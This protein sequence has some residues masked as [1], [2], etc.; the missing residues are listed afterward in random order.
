M[1]DISADLK[2]LVRLLLKHGVRFALCG[3]HA[4]AFYGFV[5]T[6]MDLD[7]LVLPDNANA[8]RLMQALAEFGFGRAGIPKSAFLREGTVVTLGVQPH[9]VDLLT[10]ISKAP[11]AAVLNASQEVEIWGMR[12][13]IVSLRDLMRAK[14]ATGRAKDKIDY[15]E[16]RALHAAPRK[17]KRDASKRGSGRPRH[18][19][20]SGTAGAKK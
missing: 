8:T 20:S 19:D 13:A 4:V 7:I 18:S 10:S 14:K 6:T 16:L 12:L 3:G 17:S 5:R 1:L 11:T 15:A 9:Q 2:D